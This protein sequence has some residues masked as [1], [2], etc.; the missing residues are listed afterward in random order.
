MTA[1]EMQFATAALHRKLFAL[2]DAG[3][4]PP[5]VADEAV[6]N[7]LHVAKPF[8]WAQDV[9]SATL[10]SSRSIPGDTRMDEDVLP[11]GLTAGWWWF[12]SPLPIQMD[13]PI[14]DPEFGLDSKHIC[15]MLIARDASGT[16]V[17]SDG[18]MS[19]MGV[20]MTG[21]LVVKRGET[22]NAIASGDVYD[23]R[24]GTISRSAEK[25]NRRP[26]EIMRF[27]AAASVWLKQRV[28]SIGDGPIER[29][30]R[31]QLAREYDAHLTDVKVIQLRRAE[32]H[33]HETDASGEPVEWSCRWIVN[34][35][36]RNQYHPS[37]G[38][39]ELKY[40]LPYVKGPDD[41][42][43]KVPNQTVYS[44]SR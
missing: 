9:A 44:V 8:H 15:A 14:D 22:I 12:E 25:R 13:Q 41:K 3:K 6:R 36:W 30:R 1:L 11:D 19:K 16:W 18:R 20:V 42:P 7:W 37:T 43:L 21:V 39:H 2:V 4:A 24:T 27:V 38:K 33:P 29:H 17:I 23:P 31:K 28:V 10:L 26:M 32:S 5:S 35:H 40:I 34:G